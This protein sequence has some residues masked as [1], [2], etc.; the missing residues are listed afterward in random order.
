MF[1]LDSLNENRPEA[2]QNQS[3]EKGCIPESPDSFIK[4]LVQRVDLNWVIQVQ[5]LD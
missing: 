2:M 3:W 4:S 5:G 1:N